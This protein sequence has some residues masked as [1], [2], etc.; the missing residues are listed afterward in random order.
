MIFGGSTSGDSNRTRKMH[1]HYLESYAVRTNQSLEDG[2]IISFGLVDLKGI[3]IPH[4]DALVIRETIAN[5]DVARAFVDFGSS[6]N[7]FFKDVLKQNE[8]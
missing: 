8:N 3:I 5:Y 1:S 2:P 6:V 7:I 4:D